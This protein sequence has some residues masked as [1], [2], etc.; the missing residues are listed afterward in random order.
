MTSMG[1]TMDLDRAVRFIVE[2]GAAGPEHN[3]HITL[4]EH[5]LGTYRVLERWRFAGDVMAAGLFH[6]VYSTQNFPIALAT[7]DERDA[8]RAVAGDGG[9]RLAFL[10]CVKESASL[11]ELAEDVARRRAL[12]TSV[13]TLRRLRDWRGEQT[14]VV[15]EREVVALLN[16][17][18][19]NAVEQLPRDDATF[20]RDLP[21]LL[22]A[23]S[24]LAREALES[25]PFSAAVPA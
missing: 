18:A 25:R 15:T 13:E 9:E 20:R 16:L 19:A 24:L 4:L 11:F 5:V 10:F 7:Y 22:R 23:S 17:V 1:L 21:G 12:G 6:S 3:S 2:R 14:H 8:V